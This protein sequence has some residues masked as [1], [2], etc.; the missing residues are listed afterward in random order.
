MAAPTAA[1]GPTTRYVGD[2]GPVAGFATIQSAVNASGPKD[3]VRVCPG[4]YDE[5]VRIVGDRAGLTLRSVEPFGAVLRSPTTFSHATHT[6]LLIRADYVRVRWFRIV[7]RTTLPCEQ[8]TYGIRVLGASG[9][10]VRGNRI[11]P[12]GGGD[13]RSGPC[14]YSDGIRVQGGA[15]AKVLWNQVTNFKRNGIYV[16]GNEA[17]S[18]V[19]HDSIHFWHPL[20]GS[21]LRPAACLRGGNARRSA[22]RTATSPSGF[23]SSVGIGVVNASA[24]VADNAVSS[25]AGATSPADQLGAGTYAY[26]EGSSAF[27]R[28]LV[29]RAANG[30]W[31]DNGVG[32]TVIDNDI[33]EGVGNG[34]LLTSQDEATVAGN[35]SHGN[36]AGIVDYDGEDS[37]F[38]VNDAL[39]NYGTDCIDGTGDYLPPDSGTDPVDNTWT[40]NVGAS[41]SPSGLCPPPPS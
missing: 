24:I 28:N 25:T 1:A 3:T 36:Q 26:G 6:I 38:T 8:T 41:S 15:S 34:I 23:V 12:T 14:G 40:G 17:R 11:A 4:T 27:E 35:K 18:I 9:A 30:I 16:V 37:A 19:K 33:A 21:C 32:S 5:E 39:G 7:A 13:A 20:T 22:A 2:C 10:I 31:L 29:R